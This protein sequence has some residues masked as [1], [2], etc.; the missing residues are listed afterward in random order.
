MFTSATEQM[1]VNWHMGHHFVCQIS[2][3]PIGNRIVTMIIDVVNPML[4]AI[5]ATEWLQIFEGLPGAIDLPVGWVVLDYIQYA[6]G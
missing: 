1:K 4:R 3:K 6:V 2:S 5:V